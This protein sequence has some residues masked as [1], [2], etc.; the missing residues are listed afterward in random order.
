[1][2]QKPSA[3]DY[4]EYA[5]LRLLMASVQAR[6]F[7]GASSLGRI[8]GSLLY[9]VDGRHRNVAVQNLRAAYGRALS[10]GQVHRL[11]RGAF[12][13]FAMVGVEMLWLPRLV[14]PGNAEAFLTP[15]SAE[16]IHRA[17]QREGGSVLLTGHLGNWE[18]LSYI[19]G[20][21]G[22]RAS[23][24]ARPLKN[25]L[26]DEY[27][28]RIRERTGQHIIARKGAVRKV[29]RQLRQGGHVAFLMDQH[30]RK[31]GVSVDFFGRPASTTRAPAALAL[32]A[33]VPLS[34]GVAIR[35]GRGLQF[36][37]TFDTDI[38]VVPTGDHD[39][40]VR[41][42]TADFTKRFERCIRRC[43]EQWLWLHRRWRA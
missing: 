36:E 38:P 33:G 37:V 24:A 14:R 10:D 11:A 32:R 7:E 28:I 9:Q 13:H 8:V 43:P 27:V 21:L 16:A 31:G 6:S 5:A 42:I 23:A 40:D 4:V 19:V 17:F 26:I 41:R 12:Q 15:G 20:A 22:Y 34:L 3:K 18:A 29:L 25:P 30:E 35:T 2:T 39:E 1:M